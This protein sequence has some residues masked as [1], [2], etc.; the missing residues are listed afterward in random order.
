[1]NGI[2]ENY[3]FCAQWL[4][5]NESGDII[6]YIDNIHCEYQALNTYLDKG[7]IVGE[8]RC[9][10]ECHETLYNAELSLS[11]WPLEFSQIS[12]FDK[13]VRQHRNASQLK[14]WQNLGHYNDSDLVSTGLIGRNFVRVNVYLKSMTIEQ[15]LERQSYELPN[16]FSDIGGTCGLW[17]GMS[18]ITWCEVFEL[19]VRVIYRAARRALSAA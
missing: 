5:R 15:Y 8:C 19:F 9:F 10:P 4:G 3:A 13:Y 6:R 2:N 12:F 1:M 18:I 7:D 11:T 14:A 16:L 17:I